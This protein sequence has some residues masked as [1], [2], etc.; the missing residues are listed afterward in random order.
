VIYK[1]YLERRAAQ[2]E[3]DAVPPG[4]PILLH[5]ACKWDAA[6]PEQ[7]AM[8]RYEMYPRLTV[9]QIADRMADIYHGDRGSTS[10]A[11]ARGM[12][13]IA[14]GAMNP[15][16]L[17]Y[18]EVREQGN[19]RVSFDLN[20]YNAGLQLK[21]VQPQLARMRQQFDIRPGEFQALYDQIK[22]RVFGHLA[23]GT[24]RNGKDF[25]NVY[26]GVQRHQA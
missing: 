11:I 8:S 2:A 16:D 14:A 12:L 15:E 13:E 1:V 10:F 23:G 9:A 5:A 24:H 7:R 18:L 20:V 26:Y 6:A 19:S 25:F 3:S 17:Q 4:T 21:D 22:G